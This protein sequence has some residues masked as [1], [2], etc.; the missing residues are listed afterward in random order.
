MRHF[1]QCK[2]VI[3]WVA[4]RFLDSHL[5]QLSAPRQR[6]VAEV[7][8]VTLTS[9]DELAVDVELAGG[10]I[11]GGRPR[12]PSNPGSR[13]LRIDELAV[14]EIPET[15]S[16]GTRRRASANRSAN[17][18]ARVGC[19]SAFPR[20]AAPRGAR[21]NREAERSALSIAS[22]SAAISRNVSFSL[23]RYSSRLAGR[24][25]TF[26]KCQPPSLA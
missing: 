6:R 18:R 22:L 3:R 17:D 9:A 26:R 19:F 8:E 12:F 14:A 24:G 20:R 15:S 10:R 1:R 25:L 16:G 23:A 7:H 21:A 4:N 13:G 11:L 2:F 5:L